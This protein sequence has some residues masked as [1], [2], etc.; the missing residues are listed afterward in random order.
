MSNALKTI[1]LI[2]FLAMNSAPVLAESAEMVDSGT[3]T[4]LPG[5]VLQISVWKEDGMDREVVVLPDGS[6]NFP[7]IGT[8]QVQGYT[9]GEVQ[10]NIK[11]KLAKLVPSASVTVA[12]KTALGHTVSV[13]GQITKPGEIIMGRRMTVMEA[14]SQAGGPT[15]YASEDSI[16]V[17]R[18]E[19]GS[20][21][22]IPVPYDDIV[23]GRHLDKDISLK[24]G[25]VVVVPTASLF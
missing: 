18:H 1:I 8:L 10:T 17:L 16:F 5:D 9:P 20:E 14:L 12:V 6:I 23:R 2:L 24:P 19:N 25:D 4:I 7:L 13:I 22:S 15:P 3:F 21:T 11:E